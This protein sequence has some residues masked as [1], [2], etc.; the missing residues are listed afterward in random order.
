MKKVIV[1]LTF[2][3]FLFSYSLED[4]IKQIKEKKYQKAL[5]TYMQIAKDGM[6]AKY[7][8][9]YLFENGLGVK[10]DIKKALQFYQMSANDGYDKAALLVGNAYIKGIGV[11]KD[12]RKAIYYYKIAA[13][14]GNKKAIKILNIIKNKLKE[15]K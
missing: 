12:I 10:K 9:G 1:F 7:N 11:K 2:F 13:K 8:I 15:K 14:E 3:S 4:G 6:I 5:K